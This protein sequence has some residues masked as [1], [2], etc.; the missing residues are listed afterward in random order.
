MKGDSNNRKTTCPAQWP[1]LHFCPEKGLWQD[2]QKQS[3]G[4][5]PSSLTEL[6][7][8]LKSQSLVSWYF[9]TKISRPSKL[10][11]KV[12][13]FFLLVSGSRDTFASFLVL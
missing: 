13:P 8:L 4:R 5:M 9:R 11:R 3:L 10:T 7:T 12:L 1:N 2:E 6:D